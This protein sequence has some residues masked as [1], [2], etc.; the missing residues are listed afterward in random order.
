[1]S[2][3][4]NIPKRLSDRSRALRDLHDAMDA[5]EARGEKIPCKQDPLWSWTSDFVGEQGT[6]ARDLVAEL[7]VACRTCPV[8]DECTRRRDD[9]APGELYGVVAG[10]LVRRSEG[11]SASF[12]GMTRKALLTALLA[13]RFGRPPKEAA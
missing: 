2:N 10:R 8:L 7:I 12:H 1:M 13:E 11:R 9:A 4:T 6:Y 3:T 5:A